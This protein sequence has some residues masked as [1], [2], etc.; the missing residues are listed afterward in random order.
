MMEMPIRLNVVSEPPEPKIL[1]QQQQH[2]RGRDPHA[3]EFELFGGGR[4]RRRGA[5]GDL[6]HVSRVPSRPIGRKIRIS[7]SST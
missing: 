2:D 5:G 6:A 3:V 1:R 4:Q 7:T